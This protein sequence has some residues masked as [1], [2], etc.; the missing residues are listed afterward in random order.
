MGKITLISDIKQALLQIQIDTEHRDF[1]QV[2]QYDDIRTDFLPSVLRFT[3]SVFGLTSSP[4]ILNVTVKFHLSQYLGQ[5]KL[6]W[7]IEKFL[8]DPY[9]DDSRSFDDADDAYYFYETA[10]SCL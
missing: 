10:K 9:V 6:K 1:L 5:E 2:L 7:V 3:R 8:Q 4:F